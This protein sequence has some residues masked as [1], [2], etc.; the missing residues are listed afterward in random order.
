MA[1]IWTEEEVEQLERQR[2]LQDRARAANPTAGMSLVRFSPER[3]KQTQREL[4]NE[5]LR[6][7]R[8]QNRPEYGE[9]LT[10][11]DQQAIRRLDKN[12]IETI[13]SQA[14][15]EK[16]LAA[17]EKE[18][19]RK[20]IAE[21]PTATL[22]DDFDDIELPET[23]RT[24]IKGELKKRGIGQEDYERYR[25]TEKGAKSREERIAE[26][27]QWLEEGKEQTAKWHRLSQTHKQEKQREKYA[28][29]VVRGEKRLEELKKEMEERRA[30]K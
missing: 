5:E 15:F 3:S 30:I 8:M 26:L 18:R 12:R 19:A 17:K 6:L 16:M 7:V 23:L 14:R 11:Q 27:D 1:K 25:I 28:R 21:T 10:E 9:G 20:E 2:E 22:I 13:R 29:W 24:E 4:R